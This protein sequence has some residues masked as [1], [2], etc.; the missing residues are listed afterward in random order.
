MPDKKQEIHKLLIDFQQKYFDYFRFSQSGVERV[1]SVKLYDD[2]TELRLKI[3]RIME[4]P[5]DR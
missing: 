4:Q 2:L 1:F 3:K 5:N